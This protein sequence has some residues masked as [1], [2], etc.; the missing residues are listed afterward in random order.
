MT[1]LGKTL[2]IIGATLVGLTLALYATI[3]TFWLDRFAGMYLGGALLLVGLVFG[4]LTVLLLNRFVSSR[5]THLSASVRRIGTLGDLSARVELSGR[6]EL[7]Q[8]AHT[9]N[10]ML[11][12]LERARRERQGAE[13]EIIALARFPEE[14]PDA[15]LRLSREAEVLY[16]NAPGRGL[17]EMLGG[18][19]QPIGHRV[20]DWLPIVGQV[21]RSG[22]RAEVELVVGDR[23]FSCLFVPVIGAGYV[24]VY[25]RDI[26]ELKRAEAELHVQHDFAMQLMN[27]MPLGVTVTD[28]AGRFEYVNPA[29]AHLLD[30]APD[31]LIGRT[32]WEVTHPEDHAVLN[33]ARQQRSQGKTTTY[34]SRLVRADGSTVYV[35]V[36]GTPRWRDGEVQGAIVAVTDLTERKQ[37]EEAL[38]ASEAKYRSIYENVHDVVYRTDFQGIL[39]AVS[40]S[41]EKH[42]G[43]R[44]E[45]VVG[46]HVLEFYSEAN[47]YTALA[48]AM[49]A[50]GTVNDVEVR[51]KGKDGCLIYTSVTARIVSDASGAPVGTEGVLRDITDRKRADA[52]IRQLN[53]ELEQRVVERT[54]ELE[55]ANRALEEERALLAQRVAER[56]ADL[57]AAN[58]E[59]ARAARLKDEFLASMS[60]ELRTPLNTVL[61]MSEALQ[62]EI[63]GPLTPEQADSL[64]SIEES[65]RH[66]LE[67]IND[68]LDL[69]K[70]EAG[71]LDLQIVPT[72]TETVCQASLR[73]IKQPAQK[74]RLHV[75]YA[76]DPTVNELPADE[77]RL[78]QILVNL[79]SNA[80]KFTPEE[81]R[82][83]LEVKGDSEGQR[84][85]FTVWDSGIGI[86]REDQGRLFQPFVQLD[87]RLSRQHNGTGLGLSL[88]RRMTEL[89]G[90]SVSLESN[91]G[92]G[93][94]FT[95][96][97]PWHDGTE[98]DQF[99]KA[100]EVEQGGPGSIPQDYRVLLVEDSP[101][102]TGQL[103]RYLSEWGFRSTIHPYGEGAVEKAQE[104][105][106]HVILL[107][108]LLPDLAGWEVLKRL[109]A[110]PRTQRIPVVIVSVV[111]ER[112]LGMAQGAADYLVKPVSREQLRSAVSRVF[113]RAPKT[114]LL[115]P[116]L[117]PSSG[118]PPLL[119]L[120]DDNE[121]NIHTLSGYL[122][123]RGYRVGVARNGYEAIERAQEDR[124]DAILM[125][126]QM[127]VMDGL[128]ATRRIRA[129]AETASIPIIALT[130]L[131]MAGDRERCLAAGADDYLSKPVS[132]KALVK[133][134]DAQLR[135]KPDEGT[136]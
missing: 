136:H 65:G 116:S 60:H 115:A 30:C 93:S 13:A 127:P 128:E 33:T 6:D 47:D 80:V 2:L 40:P 131:A 88:V 25:G 72:S 123:A 61:G 14:N 95:V 104:T 85:R 79:L 17:L 99:E 75:T 120:A 53:Q 12:A 15:V 71:R 122:R 76:P 101:A 22:Q 129:H 81:G 1:I 57:S 94:R 110:D 100:G 42:T 102:A 43:H 20:S 35:L 87:S 90:G 38:Q 9:I 36:T 84:V 34:E 108:I 103:T 10:H 119:L 91:P 78:K 86:A 28:Y 55:G 114:R 67:L 26:T 74:K 135:R 83:G 3:S 18:P 96:S 52:E 32:P 39:T 125:D 107:D 31:T 37:M 77:R 11:A 109:K 111:D 59:L 118:G 106:P 126:I 24:N 117:S 51:L 41:I 27:A 50:A 16:S 4:G 134:I 98:P 21:F 130:A 113:R 58:A 105:Q 8:L 97:F 44:P 49:E 48:A 133:A 121:A 70:I 5:L 69:S 64:H 54:A 92:Q 66:L 23:M 62:E 29:Y 89:H 124:P 132:L 73:L 46:R 112:P 82:I 45:D 68:I 19:I 56:T 63:Y 7:S